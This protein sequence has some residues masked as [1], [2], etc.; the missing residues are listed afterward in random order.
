[1]QIS[2]PA[3]PFPWAEDLHYSQ[4]VAAGEL[5]F[6]AGQGGFGPDGELVGGGFEAQLRQAFA[7]L[8]ASLEGAGASLGSVIKL[9]VFLADPADYDTWRRVRSEVLSPPWP[10]ATAVSSALLVHGMEVELEAV[11]VRGASRA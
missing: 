8:A 3:A 1:M 5:V 10:A 11:A 9:T 7:N 6:S 2:V 4:A